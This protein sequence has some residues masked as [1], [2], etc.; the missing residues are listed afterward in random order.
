MGRYSIPG[1]NIAMRQYKS[2]KLDY[3]KTKQYQLCFVKEVFLFG[4]PFDLQI[5]G[6]ELFLVVPLLD[7]LMI[8]L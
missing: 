8:S 5:P 7:P 6:G 3:V 4:P 1:A 2:I